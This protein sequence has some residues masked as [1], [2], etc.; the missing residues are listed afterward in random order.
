ME[1]SGIRPVRIGSSGRIISALLFSQMLFKNPSF[2]SNIRLSKFSFNTCYDNNHF[3]YENLTMT[4]FRQWRHLYR[5]IHKTQ[6]TNVGVPTDKKIK[7]PA[8]FTNKTGEY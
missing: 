2:Q 8:S 3:V 4:D 5:N 7:P 1:Q 6:M